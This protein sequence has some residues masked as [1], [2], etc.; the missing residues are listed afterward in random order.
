MYKYELKCVW[1][2]DTGMILLEFFLMNVQ[3]NVALVLNYVSR[4]KNP[5][6]WCWLAFNFTILSQLF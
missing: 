2:Q 1:L 6:G 5:C 4:K 3:V